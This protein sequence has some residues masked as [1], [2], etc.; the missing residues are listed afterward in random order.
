MADAFKRMDKWD[1]AAFSPENVIQRAIPKALPITIKDIIPL[2]KEGGAFVKF[3]HEEKADLKDIELK[4]KDYLKEHQIKPRYSPWTRVRGALVLGKPWIEDLYRFP[5]QR[6]KVEFLPATSNDAPTELSQEQLYSIFRQFGKILDIAS[7]PTESKVLPRYADVTFKVTRQSVLAKNCI[8][9][10]TVP[11]LD[12]GGKSGTLLRLTY[13]RIIKAHWIRDWFTSHPRIVLPLLA[14]IIATITVAIFDPVR[15]WWIKAHVTHSFGIHDQ[16]VYKWLR[17]QVT[18]AGGILNFKGRR[19]EQN[20]LK[21]IWDDRKDVIEQLKMWLMETADTFIV[22]QGP[23]GSG[24]HELVVDEALKGRRNTLVIDCKPIQ[25]ASGDSAK[26]LATAKQVGYRPVFS[27][28]NNV[29]SLLDLAAQGTL[30]TKTGFSETLDTQVAKI[31]QNTASAL[32]QVALEHKGKDEKGKTLGD[33][34]YLEAHPERRPVVVIE[35]FLHRG[36]ENSLIYDKISEWAAGVTTANIAHVI[37]LTHDVSF[38]KSLS[39]ALPD[40]VFRQVALGDCSHDVA[41]RFVLQHLDADAADAPAGEKQ[42]SPSQLRGDLAELDDVLDVVGGRLTDLE[43]LARRLQTGETPTK[44]VR[45]IIE[46]SASEILKMYLDRTR[47]SRGSSGG[48]GG[49]TPQQAWYLIKALADG[50]SLRYNE[51]LLAD[52][53]K[54]DGEAVLAA[55]EQAELIAIASENGRPRAV[56][57][58][59]PVY[60]AAFQRL[61]RD[62]VLAARLDLD[63]LGEMIKTE[64]AGIEK[65]ESELKLLG[66]LP[67]QPAELAPR[68]RWLLKKVQTGQEKVEKY[69]GESAELKKI[70]QKEY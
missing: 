4:L 40:R 41:K 59:K 46:Q 49:W 61:T 17:S 36:N 67:K 28:M 13:S 54:G 64:T 37:F 5:S 58:G 48:G 8:H 14:A 39:K 19:A 60:Q 45:E 70:L 23:R 53:Y 20:S 6:V 25:E 16:K 57:P 35:N 33:D 50:E 22:V 15:T 29:S 3:A 66:E 24:K 32:R 34:E 44:A 9:G 68:I 42:A 69:E 47:A 55:L 52:S 2:I 62:H 10:Y 30:G 12:G 63:I 56:R 21:A 27:W 51:V 1:T 7:Q 38:S 43:F 26:I 31:F 11:E 65:S 18:R